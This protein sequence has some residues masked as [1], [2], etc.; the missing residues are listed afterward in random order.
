MDMDNLAPAPDIEAFDPKGLDRGDAV[1]PVVVVVEPEVELETPQEPE[2]EEIEAPEVEEPDETPRD[3]KGKFVAKEPKIPKSRFDE[4]MQVEREAREAAERR[5]AALEQQ[6]ATQQR[7]QTQNV[8]IAEIEASIEAME[9]KHAELL[10]DGDTAGAAK[11]M[12]DIRMSERYIARAESDAISTQR[13]TQALEAQRVDVSVARLEANYPSLNPDSEAYDGD[14]VELVLSK[15]R[16]LI[17]QEGLTPSAALT[18]A[19]T[20]VMKRFGGPVEPV[21]EGKGLGAQQLAD[22]KQAQ[23]KKNLD[24]AAKQPA[25]MKDAGLDSDK[26]GAKA[27]PD[28]N[29]MTQDEFAAL[30]ASTLAKM[31]GDWV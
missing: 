21:V 27:M 25:S 17:T 6:L 9:T 18:L 5:A 31:R 30:P 1:E 13:T 23:I 20:T 24:T 28:I 29:G 3:E 19:A 26:A 10:L 11:V 7:N 8:Q 2:V 4:Q 14:L 15:Q 22:R 12:K 16:S